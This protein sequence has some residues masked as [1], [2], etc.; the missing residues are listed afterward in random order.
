MGLDVLFTS[1]SR[2]RCWHCVVMLINGLV[3]L[4]SLTVTFKFQEMYPKGYFQLIKHI[5]MIVKINKKTL[6]VLRNRTYIYTQFDAQN[7][8]NSVSELPDFKFFS[9]AC[10]QTPLSKRGLAA[11][12]QYR[13]LLFSNWLP[14]SNF[15]ETPAIIFTLWV[16]RCII[17]N[18]MKDSRDS[19]GERTHLRALW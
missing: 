4:F 6:L 16:F 2:L 5:S 15:I 9:G 14:T 13:R 1:I 12:C 10:P 7:A 19:W 17:S 11:P 8:G 18:S 3:C